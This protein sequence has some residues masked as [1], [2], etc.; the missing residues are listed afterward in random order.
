VEPATL[1]TAAAVVRG[2]L[3]KKMEIMEIMDM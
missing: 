3:M 1:A 2:G